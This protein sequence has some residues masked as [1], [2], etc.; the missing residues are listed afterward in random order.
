MVPLPLPDTQW[1][2]IYTA[3]QALPGLYVRQEAPTR[4]FLEAVFYLLRTG[5]QWRLLPMEYGA[6]NTVYQRFAR[7]DKRGVWATLFQQVATEPDLE[8][9]VLDSTTIRAHPSA[10]GASKKKAGKRRKRLDAALVVS[11]PKFIR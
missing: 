6:W 10:A 11:A 5:T 9:L 3:L 1:Q 2:V 4:R 7:W 8:W